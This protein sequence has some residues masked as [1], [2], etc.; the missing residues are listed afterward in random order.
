[1]PDILCILGCVAICSFIKVYYS[2]KDKPKEKEITMEEVL[3]FLSE[4]NNEGR[5]DICRAI[6][7]SCTEEFPADAEM[8]DLEFVEVLQPCAQHDCSCHVT[9]EDH[10]NNHVEIN[11]IEYCRSYI[12]LNKL[13]GIP[14]KLDKP[15]DKVLT[16]EEA[17][18]AADYIVGFINSLDSKK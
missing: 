10:C 2:R 5:N 3:K 1:M 14:S 13:C 15:D 9:R 18:K 16:A 17:K 7:N 11:G 6:L 4:S 12:N 8:K